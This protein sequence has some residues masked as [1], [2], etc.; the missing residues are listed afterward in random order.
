MYKPTIYPLLLRATMKNCLF[1]TRIALLLFVSNPNNLVGSDLFSIN[2][3]SKESKKVYVLG[4]MG[5]GTNN[6]AIISLYKNF[7]RAL[8]ESPTKTVVLL[9]LQ[10][11]NIQQA[12]KEAFTLSDVSYY[13]AAKNDFNSGNLTYKGL[14]YKYALLLKSIEKHLHY[15]TGTTY[16]AE[17]AEAN[18]F[19]PS[20]VNNIMT[21]LE[22]M[23][24][25]LDPFFKAENNTTRDNEKQ[26][27]K[28]KK[29]LIEQAR[30]V[31]HNPRLSSYLEVLDAYTKKIA[32]LPENPLCSEL[33]AEWPSAKDRACSY[34]KT[35]SKQTPQSE[36]V[37]VFLNMVQHKKSFIGGLD[38]LQ[39]VLRPLNI[40]I[41]LEQ[42]I[43]LF[44]TFSL[45]DKTIVFSSLFAT[46]EFIR[47]LCKIGFNQTTL[48]FVPEGEAMVRT[49]SSSIFSEEELTAHLLGV[50][51]DTLSTTSYAATQQQNSIDYYN[52]SSKTFSLEFPKNT[53]EKPCVTC[54]HKTKAHKAFSTTK[55]DHYCSLKCFLASLLAHDTSAIQLAQ[56]LDENYDLSDE[57]TL[58][59]KH[60]GAF[61]YVQAA[62]LMPSVAEESGIVYQL[63][64]GSLIDSL[65]KIEKSLQES[66]ENTRTESWNR[67]LILCSLL[68][69][70][71]PHLRS[72][73]EIYKN[74]KSKHLRTLLEKRTKGLSYDESLQEPS[75]TSSEHKDLYLSIQKQ[76][77]ASI[78]KAF[79]FENSTE[80][81]S[82]LF[83]YRE[84]VDLITK[85]VTVPFER[86]STLFTLDHQLQDLE[87]VLSSLG[88]KD[89]QQALPKKRE[90][91][92]YTLEEPQTEESFEEDDSEEENFSLVAAKQPSSTFVKPAPS[93]APLRHVIRDLF[94][95]EKP[96]TV[97][98]FQAYQWIPQPLALIHEHCRSNWRRTQESKRVKE[99]FAL[100]YEAQ[101]QGSPLECDVHGSPLIKYDDKFT[102]LS[103][104]EKLNL[105]HL[106]TR[107]VDNS[108]LSHGICEKIGDLIQISIPGELAY[109]TTRKLG[110]FQYSFT[111]EWVCIHRCFKSYKANVQNRFVSSTLR[112]ILCDF[113][114]TTDLQGE[115]KKEIRELKGTLAL[116]AYRNC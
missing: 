87:T 68:K 84:L 102:H 6:N 72:S 4:L 76:W 100:A 8:S 116:S 52:T 2:L 89:A 85:R 75:T 51:Q 38:E 98:L 66:P 15:H 10:K 111:S 60:V 32:E 83:L 29:L 65:K 25:A 67:T 115:Y 3:L 49:S 17:F 1:F 34:I 112:R 40:I 70:S 55:T 93:Q 82:L 97:T 36:L 47:P 48:G 44:E 21:F 58:V 71:L 77:F 14:D 74:I 69:I 79:D 56:L 94:A 9:P 62:L 12:S 86:I 91:K 59:L 63:P 35:Y 101:E 113:L 39:K 20:W 43:L 19:S 107:T 16:I 11:K 27:L 61:C 45:Y 88:E 78:K 53:T 105:D 81:G 7:L 92:L 73:L 99:L 41:Q 108:L 24:P 50:V 110:F 22:S 57:D 5:T 26:F 80:N 109:D 54:T 106:F 104:L 28:L 90:Q 33:I 95:D 114:V 64:L 96:Y 37:E 23:D 30:K 13:D 31:N 103:I 42:N 18:R 46:Q